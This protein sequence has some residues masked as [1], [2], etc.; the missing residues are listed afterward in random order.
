[1]PSYSGLWNGIYGIPYSA[2]STNNTKETNNSLKTQVTKH[3]SKD[4]GAR[5]LM[6]LMRTLNG[7]V[8]GS[9]A[10]VNYKQIAVDPGNNNP[11]SSGGK[12]TINTIADLN[13]A[14]TAADQT[15]INAMFDK[16]FAP[17]P[18]PV[19]KSSNGG[20]NKRNAF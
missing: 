20:G 18:Y 7:V 15:L 2:L 5:K 14:T 1:M 17:S 6:M 12:R 11:I 10:T 8:A 13:R 19:D 16:V 4:R 3:L 9:T